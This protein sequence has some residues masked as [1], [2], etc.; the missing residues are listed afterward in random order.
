MPAT[1]ERISEADPRL[2]LNG[3]EISEV[4][5]RSPSTVYD[6]LERLSAISRTVGNE[7]RFP[8]KYCLILAERWA[9]PSSELWSRL[10]PVFAQRARDIDADPSDIRELFAHVARAWSETRSSKTDEMFGDSLR[11]NLLSRLRA[12]VQPITDEY[13]ALARA[14]ETSE[15]EGLQP[16]P[17]AKLQPHLLD[18]FRAA[19]DE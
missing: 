2:W 11:Q 4:V 14:L 1:A 8:W 13:V 7:N 12:S 5:R 9:V 10:E 19:L 17:S 16:L 15:E 18:D 6:A 3:R